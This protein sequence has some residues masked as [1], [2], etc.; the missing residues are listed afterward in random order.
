MNTTAPPLIVPDLRTPGHPMAT[1][2]VKLPADCLTSLQSQADQI[3]TTRS[4]LA[5]ALVVQGLQR[6]EAAAAGEVA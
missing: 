1:L 3:G 2:P 6:L 5:R 4:A